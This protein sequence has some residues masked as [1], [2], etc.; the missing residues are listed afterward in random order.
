MKAGINQMEVYANLDVGGY[1]WA[2]YGFRAVDGEKILDRLTIN[3]SKLTAEEWIQAG[4]I[5]DNF[6]K[7]HK[8]TEPFPMN[9][10][11]NTPFGHRLLDGRGINWE[12]VL[13]LTDPVHR[14][15]FESYLFG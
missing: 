2:S 3:K 5:I 10:L 15:D 1:C 8:K 7:V 4:D 14:A 9:L 12:G 11:S 13:D 6:Y